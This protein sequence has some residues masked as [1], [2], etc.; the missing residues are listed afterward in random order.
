MDDGPLEPVEVPLEDSLDLHSFAPADVPSVVEE[1]VLAARAAGLAE[2]R[3]IHGRGRGVQKARVHSLLRRI[4]GVVAAFE[5]PSDRGGWG[6][7]VVR[8]APADVKDTL[9]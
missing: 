9:P 8:L 6:A 5:A 3:L 2:V 7:T 4:P 1:Y